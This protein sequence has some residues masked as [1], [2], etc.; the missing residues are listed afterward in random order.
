MRTPLHACGACVASLTVISMLSGCQK[1]AQVVS[2]ERESSNPAIRDAVPMDRTAQ[3][4]KRYEWNR[5]VLIDDYLQFGNRNPKWDEAATNAMEASA[6]NDVADP[7]EQ[8]VVSER[9]ARYAR[10][11]VQSGCDDPIL[12]QLD[13]FFGGLAEVEAPPTAMSEACATNAARVAGSGYHPLLK[14]YAFTSAAKELN[15]VTG[16]NATSPDVHRFRRLALNELLRTLDDPDV[17]PEEV[18]NACKELITLVKYNPQQLREFYDAFEPR[19]VQNWSAGGLADL[20]KGR[21][22]ISYAW[23]ARGEDF[24]ST[25]KPE[26]WRLFA[27]R[28]KTAEQALRSAWNANPSNPQIPNEMLTVCLGAEKNRREMEA[29]FERAMLLNAANAEA[30]DRKLYYLNPKWHGSVEEMIDFGRECTRST[31]WTGFVP[32]YVVDAYRSAEQYVEESRRAEYWKSPQ[33]W[34]DISVAYKGFLAAHPDCVSRRHWFAWWAYRCGHYEEFTNQLAQL[35]VTNS[36]Y[37]GG[38][39]E[40]EEMLRLAARAPGRGPSFERR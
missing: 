9:C 16:R 21:F 1:A 34:A 8:E 23:Q 17:P 2:T 37:F 30:C 7:I 15:A 10:Q 26:Q 27:E 35:A 40:L 5:Q 38:G 13:L 29:W 32:L 25:V 4:Q 28:L 31:N 33:I 6:R 22:Y 20:I 14:F 18:F 12:L 36:S 24:A 11:A 3:R 39:K 19:L